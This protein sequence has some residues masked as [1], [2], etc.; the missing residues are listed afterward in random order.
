MKYF[1][2]GI[3]DAM[4]EKINKAAA[5]ANLSE[6]KFIAEILSRYIVDAHIMESKEVADGYIECGP[7][8]LELANQ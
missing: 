3:S 7:L 1:K 2:V 8:N 6:E 4:S 5:A